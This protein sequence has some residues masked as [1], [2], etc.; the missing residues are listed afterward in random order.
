MSSRSKEGHTDP[1]ETAP[2]PS[3]GLAHDDNFGLVRVAEPRVVAVGALGRV[4]PLHALAFVQHALKLGPE[5]GLLVIG[6]SGDV[7][8]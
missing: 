6:Q 4:D 3:S 7:A 5:G 8:L 2:H 1:R